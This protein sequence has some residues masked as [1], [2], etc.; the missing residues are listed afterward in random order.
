MIADG[1]LGLITA[2][3]NG[4]F[5]ALPAWTLNPDQVMGTCGANILDNQDTVTSNQSALQMIVIWIQKY[6]TF[7]PF[8]QLVL[9]MTTVLTFYGVML[10]YK[11]AKFIIGVIRGAG[12]S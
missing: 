6:N 10:A 2:L 3:I 1:F 5:S 4:L 8:D 12:T 9:V 7:V 11:A